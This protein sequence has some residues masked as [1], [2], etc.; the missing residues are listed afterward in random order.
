MI[1]AITTNSAA[2][3]RRPIGN[4][5]HQGVMLQLAIN[6]RSQTP[7]IRCP[8]SGKV[9]SIGWDSLMELALQDGVSTPIEDAFESVPEASA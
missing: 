8:E 7:V 9:W 4:R 5:R 6:P 2:I 3:V 1:G